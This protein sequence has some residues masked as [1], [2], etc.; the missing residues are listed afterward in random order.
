MH[1][2]EH[3]GKEYNSKSFVLLMSDI[4]HIPIGIAELHCKYIRLKLWI[5]E[6]VEVF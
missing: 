6:D 3:W 5:S 2:I 1:Y 4:D